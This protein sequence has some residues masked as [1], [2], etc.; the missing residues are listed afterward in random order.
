MKEDDALAQAVF[1]IN[2]EL[3][4]PPA[5]PRVTTT[6]DDGMVLLEW[7]YNPSD[8]NYLDSYNAI[9][10]LL[11]PDV[12]DNDYLFEG[13][14]VYQYADAGDQEGTLLA[15]YDRVNGITRVIEGTD[16]T[17]ITA[18]GND[19][20][21]Q[22][23][24]RVTGL[25]NYQDYE[26]GIQAYAYNATSGQKVYAGP[27]SRVLAI[28][29]ITDKVLSEDALV[30]AG[31]SGGIDLEG[32]GGASNIGNGTVSA[33]IV[34][35]AAVTGDGYSVDFYTI[36]VEVDDAHKRQDTHE[37]N[38]A[39]S[40]PKKATENI[41]VYNVTNTATGATL[42]N[43][44]D[45][46]AATHLVPIGNDVVQIDGLSLNV[47]GPAPGFTDFKVTANAG[48]PLA[49][50]EGAS[51]DWGGFPGLGRPTGPNQQVALANAGAGNASGW[52][53]AA[54]GQANNTYA[55][56]L[57]R[58]ARNGPV[59]GAYD[60]E[61][62][63]TGNG[64]AF[65]QWG[66]GQVIDVPFELWNTGIGTPDDT[67]DDFQYVPLIFDVD[68]NC[69]FNLHATDHPQSGGTNDPF[70]DW[71]YW[72]EGDYAAE[73]A[74]GFDFSTL[75]AEIYGRTVFVGWNLDDVSDGTIDAPAE[76]QMPETGTI[77]RI[78]TTKPNQPGDV[79]SVSTAGLGAR[80]RTDAE[81]RAAIDE[82]GITPNPYKGASSY[83]VSQLVDEVRFTNMPDQ[84]T[85]RVF[86][87]NGSLVTTLRKN[88]SSAHFPWDL[89]TD[90]GLPVASGM[91][92][93]HVETEFG[94]KVLKLGVVKKRVQL[95]VF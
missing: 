22:H 16:L 76:L 14:S 4:S 65:V 54:G 75:G 2:F 21:V 15:T 52:L 66:C 47:L 46:Y 92:I 24:H 29:Q 45:A 50:P 87:V 3:P 25:T 19:N 27:V 72:Y 48:G 60:Y 89:T 20:G 5:G 70:T 68:D 78:E 79:F 23:F 17:F 83:E 95:N 51:G 55:A 8:N 59:Y 35:P 6:V 62:R 12:T 84:A 11:S 41:T 38:G 58:W 26:F 94:D 74:S 90:D 33:N 1:D 28:P 39:A 93:I 61:V 85:I 36:E 37:L 18:D 34:N 40:L 73:V 64:K 53:I 7:G 69:A 10:P 32:A 63:F 77:F 56:F 44:E 9:D 67:S 86:A 80:D 81:A 31:T 13:Y 42:F 82:I 49:E 43:G 88:S 30:A 57:G 71:I 91:Y